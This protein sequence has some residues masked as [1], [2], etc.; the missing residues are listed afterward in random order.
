MA[1]QVGLEPEK[2]FHWVIDPKVKPL[3]LFA[4]GKIDAFLGFPPEPQE[5]RARHAG[6]VIL[7]TT[8]D[9]PWSQYFCCMLVATGNTSKGTRSRPGGCCAPSS[10]PPTSAPTSP[11]GLRKTFRSGPHRAIRLP[12][13]GPERTALLQLAGLRRRGHDPV[14]CPAPLR[15]GFDQID[16]KQDRRKYRLALLRRTQARAEGVSTKGGEAS[17]AKDA[18]PTPLFDDAVSG[19]RRRLLRTPRAL[20]ARSRSK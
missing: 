17:N 9:R 7:D 8:V 16:T 5:L 2:D 4:E 12:T 1:A 6:H 14:L 13:S 19:R 18:D 10:R 15:S 20:G 3:D 11:R